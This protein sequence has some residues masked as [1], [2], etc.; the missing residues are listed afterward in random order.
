MSNDFNVPDLNLTPF[1]VFLL[2]IIFLFGSILLYHTLKGEEQV[3]DSTYETICYKIGCSGWG[4][5]YGK[6]DCDSP[7]V[8]VRERVENKENCRWEKKK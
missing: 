4:C 8:D 5:S 7:N 2:I 1:F 3:C 6:V